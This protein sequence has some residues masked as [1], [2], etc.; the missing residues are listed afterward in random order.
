MARDIHSIAIPVFE[1]K[2][3]KFGL[4]ETF[5]K[6]VIDAF[7]Q[8]NR[9]KVLDKESAESILLG[10]ITTYTREPFS[11][12]DQEHVKDYKIVVG[13]KLTYKDKE[14][15]ALSDKQVTD[16]YLYSSEETEEQGIDGLCKK[17][18]NDIVRGIL[19]GW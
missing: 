7:I 10:E 1:N 4:E 12:D 13:M 16:W 5:T 8:D 15:K 2:T 19:E 18:A 14:G 6:S 11:Y 17:F 9:M 3:I